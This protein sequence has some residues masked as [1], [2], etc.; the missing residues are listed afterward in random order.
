MAMI[1]AVSNQKGGVGKTTTA[2]NLAASMAAMHRRVLLIDLDPQG[3]ATGA[4]GVEKR[5]QAQTINEV[6]LQGA[7]VL[8]AVAKTLWGYDVLPANGDLTVAEV[9]LLAREGR[10]YT[11]KAA[12]ASVQDH[13]DEI[14]IDCPPSLSMLTVNAWVAAKRVVVPMQCEYF[15]LEGLTS[16][17]SS[18]EQVKQ[19]ANRQ[20]QLGGIV[21]TMYDGR[22]R[23][24]QEVSMQLREH[25]DAVLFDTVI[26]RTVRLAEAPSHGMPILHYDRQSP[27][28]LA[29]L[30]LAGEWV[31]RNAQEQQTVGEAACLSDVG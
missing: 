17:V 23:L 24:A 19:S 2:V 4:S 26:P 13:Y 31:K 22:N 25:F 1:I 7:P 12:L 6:L 10:E 3:N 5:K 30:A 29:Y 27:G 20:L 15:A 28:A 8:S 16:L 14:W 11:L 9:R 21:R 18:I